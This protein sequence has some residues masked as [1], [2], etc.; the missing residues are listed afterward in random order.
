MGSFKL[1]ST[2]NLRIAIYIFPHPVR[3]LDMFLKQFLLGLPRDYV[4]IVLRTLSSQNGWRSTKATWWI[5][6]TLKTK[7]SRMDGSCPWGSA[8][9]RWVLGA[10]LLPNFV[11]D[12]A[13]RARPENVITYCLAVAQ[14][15][16]VD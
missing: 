8:C 6:D 7:I 3:T 15:T 4:E 16:I 2:L 14:T 1:M 11:T 10:P 9:A 12:G 13:P 5:K